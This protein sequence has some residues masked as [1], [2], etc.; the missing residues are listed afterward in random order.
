MVKVW[1][2]NYGYENETLGVFTTEKLAHKFL[3][4]HSREHGPPG[5]YG[6]EVWT[7]DDSNGVVTTYC[8]ADVPG[9]KTI[10]KKWIKSYEKRYG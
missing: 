1:I 2:V 4:E 6:V 3:K 5:N 10:Q 8:G 9:T 7:T